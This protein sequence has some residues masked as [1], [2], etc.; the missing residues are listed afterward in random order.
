MV[1]IKIEKWGSLKGLSI[2]ISKQIFIII[3][4][5]TLIFLGSKV[6]PSFLIDFLTKYSN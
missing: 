3:L 5:L 6:S 4:F 1:R 2:S